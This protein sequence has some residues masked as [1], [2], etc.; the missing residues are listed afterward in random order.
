MHLSLR[1]ALDEAVGED[2]RAVHLTQPGSECPMRP[3]R[4]SS[5][6]ASR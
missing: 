6:A 5:V 3:A 4:S 1:P 2:W